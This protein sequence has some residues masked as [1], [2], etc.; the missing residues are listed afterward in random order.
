MQQKS[1]AVT[2]SDCKNYCSSATYFVLFKSLWVACLNK[3]IKLRSCR[4]LISIEVSKIGEVVSKTLDYCFVIILQIEHCFGEMD[5]P[6]ITFLKH[7]EREWTVD[8]KLN[9]CQEF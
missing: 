8:W 1:K 7:P 5:T 6:L 2:A 9:F 3:D 4:T